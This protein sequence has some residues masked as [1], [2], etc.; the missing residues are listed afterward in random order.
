MKPCVL[1][2]VSWDGDLPLP[3]QW[4]RAPRGRTAY[5]ILEV[6]RPTGSA[7]YAAKLVCERH[8][9]SAPRFEDTVYGWQWTKRGK[10]RK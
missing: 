10:T 5:M 7:T 3:G 1:T 6:K 4:I 9:H 2:A 8:P